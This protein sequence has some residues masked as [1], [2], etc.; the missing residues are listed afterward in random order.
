[1]LDNSKS[2]IIFRVIILSLSAKINLNFLVL[3]VFVPFLDNCVG[4]EVGAILLE[5]LRFRIFKKEKGSRFDSFY[6]L[7]KMAGILTN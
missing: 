7:Q 2:F 4:V 1:M 5:W 6:N 3:L